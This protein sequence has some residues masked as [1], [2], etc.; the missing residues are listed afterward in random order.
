MDALSVFTER[1][2]PHL[3][4][5]SWQ[6]S[7]L[8]LVIWIVERLS[9]KASSLFRYWLWLI[10]LIRLCIP[11]NLTLPESINH[12]FT[13]K[14][15][16]EIPSIQSFVERNEIPDGFG[17]QELTHSG[18]NENTGNFST[19]EPAK[20]AL[21][22]KISDVAA[23]IWLVLFLFIGSLILYR[24]IRVNRSLNRCEPIKRKDLCSLFGKLKKDMGLNSSVGL[25]NID[26]DNTDMPAVIGILKPRVF[27]PRTIAENWQIEDIEPLLLHELAHIKRNDHV[28]N[29]L[30]VF[31]QIVYFFHPVVWFV[32]HRI[33]KLREQ[34]S[35]DLA[36]HCLG[37]KNK[38]YSM[39]I[40]RVLE[41]SVKQPAFGFIGIGFSERKS[42]AGERIKR[43]MD[44]N[45]VNK[46][47]MTVF[48]M[49]LVMIIGIS[50]ILFSCDYKRENEQTL[51]VDPEQNIPN[52]ATTENILSNEKKEEMIN[53]AFE[54]FRGGDNINLHIPIATVKINGLQSPRELNQGIESVSATVNEYIN[55]NSNITV[56]NDVS[57][58]SPEL[59]KFPMLFISADGAFKLNESESENLGNYLRN[60]GF[61]FIDNGSPELEYGDAEASLRIM[62][63]DCLGSDARFL[64]IPNSHPVYHCFFDFDDGPPRGAEIEN[65]RDK[66]LEGIWL[67]NRLAAVYS[68]KGYIYKWSENGQNTPQIALGM[69]M[70]LF[71]ILQKSGMLEMFSRSNDQSPVKVVMVPKNEIIVPRNNPRNAI[72]IFITENGEYKIGDKTIASSDLLEELLQIMEEN[73]DKSIIIR[74]SPF[75]PYDDIQ[76]V[77]KVARSAGI[78]SVLKPEKI[79]LQN[80]INVFI[81]ENGEYKVGDKTIA[82]S[83]LLKV[84][85]EEKKNKDSNKII[86]MKTPQTRDEDVSFAENIAQ[87]AGI[88][89]VIVGY[90]VVSEQKLIYIYPKESLLQ[91][92]KS[93]FNL[94]FRL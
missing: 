5:V 1:L 87:K 57:L 67:N 21:S 84:V 11:L 73:K 59:F 66:Y 20:S 63:K 50:G 82:S 75:T 4:A 39:S 36:L 13:E 8:F 14:I 81:T 60:G 25:Y 61:V 22:E 28:V 15:G 42:F 2:I 80:A 65:P 34:L 62:L 92:L 86:I 69:N 31:I 44:T 41:N 68:D 38:H 45:Y 93:S 53:K 35:D 10:V 3:W 6:V 37:M 16:I 47:K 7:I 79:N 76:F 54:S 27:L 88:E 70:V 33:R 30:Q 91:R 29:F 77:M 74:S 9:F 43:I 85:I 23:K 52:T 72:N 58:D 55:S 94:K 26:I 49:I 78:E 48:S 24:I 71:P 89:I 40:L 56:V 17:F 46:T 90:P 19:I 83:D 18:I 64:P 12:L 32:N 51:L